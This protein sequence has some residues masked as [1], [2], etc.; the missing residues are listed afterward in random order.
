MIRSFSGR[1]SIFRIF[2]AE[3][4]QPEYGQ[5]GFGTLPLKLPDKGWMQAGCYVRRGQTEIA[6]PE[7]LLAFPVLALF[8]PVRCYILVDFVPSLK[9]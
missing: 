6:P 2:P 3:L 1:R 9:N 8:F 5:A 7:V 4:R